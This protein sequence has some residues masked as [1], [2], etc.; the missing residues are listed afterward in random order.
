MKVDRL[1]SIKRYASSVKVVPFCTMDESQWIPHKTK[2]GKILY[3]IN[4]ATGECKWQSQL[5]K[6]GTPNSC[7]FDV[8]VK[9]VKTTE[10]S[11]CGEHHKKD[12]AVQET[13]QHALQFTKGIPFHKDDR[14]S[15]LQVTECESATIQCVDHD[16]RRLMSSSQPT[17]SKNS[18]AWKNT[19][20][21]NIVCDGSNTQQEHRILQCPWCQEKFSCPNKL[22]SHLRS[23]PEIDPLKCPVCSKEYASSTSLRIHLRIHTGEKPFTCSLCNKSFNQSSHL[24]THMRVHTGEKPYKCPQCPKTF[25]QS[26]HLTLHVRVHNGEKPFHCGFCSKG[27]SHSSALSTHMRTHTGEKPF[28]CPHCPKRFGQS[29]HLKIHIRTHTG[30]RPFQC[31]FCHKHFRQSCYL[32]KHLRSHSSGEKTETDNV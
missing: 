9:Q 30:E 7:E 4:P 32:A 27:F 17:S 24:T 19:E 29:S 22:A 8:H 12:I 3:Y 23:H 25:G 18:A 28:Q 1:L 13:P 5:N 31:H 2:T 14:T 16:N 26:S 10:T 6:E 20:I 15:C 21:V 11:T